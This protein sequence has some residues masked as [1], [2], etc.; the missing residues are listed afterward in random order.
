MFGGSLPITDLAV[1]PLQRKLL[2]IY[3]PFYMRAPTRSRLLMC[4]PIRLGTRM[5]SAPSIQKF[6][7]GPTAW[8]SYQPTQNL[9]RQRFENSTLQK[10]GARRSITPKSK[11]PSLT[12]TTVLPGRVKALHR[13]CVS[14]TAFQDCEIVM[15]PSQ[16]PLRLLTPAP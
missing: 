4:R 8:K 16:S 5:W 9:R 13:R 12:S 2:T 14:H 10:T 1:H 15:V 11:L 6:G 3:E 7:S